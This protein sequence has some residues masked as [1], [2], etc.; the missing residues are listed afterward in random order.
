VGFPFSFKDIEKLAAGLGIESELFVKDFDELVSTVSNYAMRIS[1]EAGN[2][3]LAVMILMWTEDLTSPKRFYEQIPKNRCQVY[4]NLGCVYRRSG[5]LQ[6]ALNALE[7]ALEITEVSPEV[8]KTITFLNITAVLSQMG[9]Y[10]H[11]FDHW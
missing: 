8:S 4:N 9:M 6:L 1:Q 2:H 7:K 5:K 11:Y 3:E 10:E